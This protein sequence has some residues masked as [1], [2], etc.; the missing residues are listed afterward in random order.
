MKTGLILFDTK[1]RALKEVASSNGESV[2]IYC[3]AQQ[4]TEM[5]MLEICELFYSET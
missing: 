2:R 1:E 4:F 5:P 3:C